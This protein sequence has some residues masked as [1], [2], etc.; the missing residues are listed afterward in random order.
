MYNLP[1]M[2]G[3]RNYV[4]YFNVIIIQIAM[5]SSI[6]QLSTIYNKLY[7][8]IIIIAKC[9]YKYSSFHFHSTIPHSTHTVDSVNIL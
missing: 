8:L 3:F 5:I 6:T 2:I 1:R 9:P 4:L 7:G